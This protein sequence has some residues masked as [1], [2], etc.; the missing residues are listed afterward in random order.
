ML[1]H[2]KKF[3]CCITATG[4]LLLN[5]A[6]ASAI[7]IKPLRIELTIDPGNSATATLR[8]INSEANDL[9]LKP[10]VVIYTKNDEKGFPVAEELNA[11]NPANIR[12]WITF[13]DSQIELPAN[14]EKAVNFTVTV[15]KDAAAGG[16]YASV[17]Y[18]ATG[19]QESEG[20]L[21]VNTAVPSLILITVTGNLTSTGSFEKI[22][23][24]D[25][26]LFSDIFPTFNLS[27]KNTGNL[28]IKPS[29]SVAIFDK[30]TGK[31]L[32]SIARY[33]NPITGET[34]VA[35]TIP[36]NLTGGNVLPGSL[37]IFEAAWNENI[38]SGKFT[39]KASLN[40]AKGKPALTKSMD[41]E[42]AE[43]L[44]TS[45]FKFIQAED[46]AYFQL[47]ATNKG[48]VN[49]KLTGKVKITNEFASVVAAPKIPEDIPYIKPGETVTIQIPW[50]SK[51]LPAGDYTAELLAEYGFAKTPVTA[52]TTFS[53]AGDNLLL[54]AGI[55]G[56][57]VL[58][59]AGG[60]FAYRLGRRKK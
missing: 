59:L 38:A 42:I 8:V 47:T 35:D 11:D 40:Y 20:S 37:R 9:A 46:S 55:G 7:G 56:G 10:E 31:Q 15:P 32:T 44:Q 54:Y 16:R 27:F 6:T 5:L 58:F 29:G 43:D 48:N 39:A 14:S 34:V 21:Q 26:A 28:H 4:V 3:L 23:L 36:I 24:K 57:V 22:A 12:S 45:D 2:L 51:T 1:P 17:M 52:Q 49:E 30:T 18:V 19:A 41:F 50:L 60:F 25:A 33:A 13:E 53:S